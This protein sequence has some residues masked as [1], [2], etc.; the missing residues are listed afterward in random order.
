MITG[1]AHNGYG[2]LVAE[3]KSDGAFIGEAGLGQIDQPTKDAMDRPADIE[4]G[5]MFGQAYWGNGYAPEAAAAILAHSWKTLD[6]P[7]I[8]A[9]TYVGNAPSRRVMEKIGMTY[10]PADDFE[11]PTVPVG[12]WQRPHVV[13]RARNPKR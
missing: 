9:F 7:E 10:D 3:R 1:L 5:W 8:I 11:D 12:H 13:Y 4:I 2:F 6:V